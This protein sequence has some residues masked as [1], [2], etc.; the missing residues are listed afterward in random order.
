M[1]TFVIA[2]HCSNNK[3]IEITKNFIQKIRETFTNSKILYVD[4]LPCP[5]ELTNLVDFSLH[6][7]YNPILN[8]DLITD[9]T[10]QFNVPFWGVYDNKTIIK[11]VPNHSYAHHDSLYHAFSFLYKNDLGEIIHFLNYDCNEDTFEFIEKNHK[12]LR[13]NEAKAVF[14]PYRYDPE[15]GVCTEFFSLSK[16]ALENW[17]LHLKDFG[18]YENRN[19]VRPKDYNIEYTYFSHLNYR[20]IKYHVHDMWP[21]RGGEVG[22][23]NFQD[24]NEND[25]IIIKYNNPNNKL[26]SVV[27]I[28]GYKDNF[29][30]RVFLMRFGDQ[31]ADYFTFS[32]LDNQFNAVGKCDYELKTNDF[33][34]I[35]PVENS[36]YVSIKYKNFVMSFDLLDTRN[37]GRVI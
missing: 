10:E 18:S 13:D 26:L 14:F 15:Q 35:D 7:K 11:T 24:I 33:M 29:N 21:T 25:D 28:I 23:S 22:N 12:I 2:G 30:L 32:F 6:V 37:Y 9:I 16:Y 5:R 3:K 17:F 34:Y 1:K 19:I 27:P 20:N 36:R 8:F 31:I 4:H